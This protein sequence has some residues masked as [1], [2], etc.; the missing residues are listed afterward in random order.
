LFD[1]DVYTFS[2]PHGVAI[3]VLRTTRLLADYDTVYLHIKKT[4]TTKNTKRLSQ[5]SKLPKTDS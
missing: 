4:N 2:R 1:I 5:E 3:Y